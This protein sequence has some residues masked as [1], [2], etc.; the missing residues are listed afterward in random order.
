MLDQMKLYNKHWSEICTKCKIQYWFAYDPRF[1]TISI[2]SPYKIPKKGSAHT[3]TD[4]RHK[5]VSVIIYL[6]FNC[7]WI[8]EVNSVDRT[9]FAEWRKTVPSH[10]CIKESNNLKISYDGR[11][12]FF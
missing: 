9:V 5:W 6:Y 11:P 7:R 1:N 10:S 3:E 4:S 8:F 12:D 2:I